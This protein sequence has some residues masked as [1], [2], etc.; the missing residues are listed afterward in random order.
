[1]RIRKNKDDRRL[2]FDIWWTWLGVS[3]SWSSLSS[4]IKLRWPYLGKG[5]GKSKSHEFTALIVVWVWG[6]YDYFLDL[7]SWV[8]EVRQSICYEHMLWG[9]IRLETGFMRS[10]S[11]NWRL[12][13]ACDAGT[14]RDGQIFFVFY[15]NKSGRKR[16]CLV[17]K[18]VLSLQTRHVWRRAPLGKPKKGYYPAPFNDFWKS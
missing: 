8:W 3:N 12:R 4:S 18:T 10:E 17:K 2:S 15:L 6:D 1:M 9:N 14:R 11:T 5:Y 16:I 7:G 13:S